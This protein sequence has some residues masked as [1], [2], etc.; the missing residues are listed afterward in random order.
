MTG[1]VP[2]LVEAR[3]D[4]A[5]R[6]TGLVRK[7]AALGEAELAMRAGTRLKLYVG[8]D[9]LGMLVAGGEGEL[10]ALGTQVMGA[11]DGKES[12]SWL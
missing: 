3:G 10:P 4:S 8:G 5:S 1:L 7:R 11:I 12:A 6:D 2:L 9:T